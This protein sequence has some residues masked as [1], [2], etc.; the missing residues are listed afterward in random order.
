[1]PRSAGVSF[2]FALIRENRYYKGMGSLSFTHLLLLVLILLLFFGPSKLPQLGQSI[3]RAIRGFKEGLNEID[4]EA[5]DVHTKNENQQ[6]KHDQQTRSE[7]HQTETSE[8]KKS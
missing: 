5:R 8:H 2:Y 7:Q 3:G 1:M 4:G 6:L